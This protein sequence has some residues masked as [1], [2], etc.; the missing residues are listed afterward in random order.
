M[1]NTFD[2]FCP[3]IRSQLA[4]RLHVERSHA[5]APSVCQ[6]DGSC[7]SFFPLF[8]SVPSVVNWASPGNWNGSRSNSSG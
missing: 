2:D 3:Y 8:L 5:Q 4:E 1:I 7:L 6:V